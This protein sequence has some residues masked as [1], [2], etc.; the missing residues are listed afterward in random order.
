MRATDLLAACPGLAASAGSACASADIAPSPTLLA[1][2]LTPEAARAS[3]RLSVGRFTS[4]AEID[5]AA[6]LLGAAWEK[7]RE[8]GAPAVPASQRVEAACLP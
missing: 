6:A 1:M 5:E 2:G 3:L 7:L 4:A 8:R